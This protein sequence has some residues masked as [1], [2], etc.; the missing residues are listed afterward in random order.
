[1]AN[2]NECKDERGGYNFRLQNSD[3]A[4]SRGY[5]PISTLVL[6]YLRFG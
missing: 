6:P 3:M 5:G 4:A 2:G 1:M